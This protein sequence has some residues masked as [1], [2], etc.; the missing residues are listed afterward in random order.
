MINRQRPI[1]WCVLVLLAGGCLTHGNSSGPTAENHA[2]TIKTAGGVEMAPVS[3]GWFEMGS[4][5]EDQTDEHAHRVF[6]SSF[7]ID[8]CDVT[9]EEYERLIGKNPSRWKNPRNPVE[10]IRWAEAIA[11]CN[12]RSREDG[13]RPAYDVATGQCDFQAAGYRLPTEAEWEYAARAGTKSAYSFGDNPA[14]LGR[15]AWFK[16]NST[17]GTHPVGQKPPN[18]W[19]LYDMGGNVWKWCNDF[20]KEDSYRDGPDHDPRGPSA[21]ENRVVRGGCW[22]SRPDECRS[23]YRNYEMPAFTDV[24]FAKEVHGAIGFRCVRTK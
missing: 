14:E 4:A 12:A 18:A 15:Y 2:T 5:D 17:R 19:G 11:Y 13:L 16:E 7:H 24:C 9:Q 3:G 1:G 8:R 20:Y 22:N 10:Q 21:G 6:V 23:A